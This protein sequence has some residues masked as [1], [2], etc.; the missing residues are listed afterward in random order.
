MLQFLVLISDMA[1]TYLDM[2]SLATESHGKHKAYS[3]ETAIRFVRDKLQYIKLIEI[4]T[5][6]E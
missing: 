1:T 3:H 4:I 5:V 2:N 6:L